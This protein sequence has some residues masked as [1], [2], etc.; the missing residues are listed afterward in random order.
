ME[1]RTS[2]YLRKEMDI[3]RGFKPLE[4]TMNLIDELDYEMG[5][6]IKVARLSQQ[7]EKTSN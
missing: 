5:E 2:L 4:L 1:L 7:L 3:K 6:L